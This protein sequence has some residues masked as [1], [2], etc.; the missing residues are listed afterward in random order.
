MLFRVINIC[1]IVMPECLCRASSSPSSNPANEE[2]PAK[3]TR[4]RREGRYPPNCPLRVV[5]PECHY[6]AS[7]VPTNNRYVL[8]VGS[9]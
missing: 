8:Q 9:R 3:S 5:M 6:R 4:E 1:N 2:V 7:I